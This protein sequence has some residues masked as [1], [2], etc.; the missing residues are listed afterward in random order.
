[1]SSS[2]HARGGQ[3]GVSASLV[4]KS[5]RGFV[6]AVA[7]TAEAVPAGGSVAALSGASA[8]AL[9]A[10]V[11]GVLRRK[12]TTGLA[13]APEQALELEERLLALV[14][15]DA[16]AFRAFLDD[17]R[18]QTAIARVSQAPLQVA[19]ACAEVVDLSRAVEERTSGPM[20]G[21]VRAARHLANAA[22]LAALDIAEQDVALQRDANARD[23]LTAQIEQLRRSR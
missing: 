7:S 4:E 13:G 15:E 21:D 3:A 18:S 8:A 23:S 1:M 12:E 2:S 10:L 5:V 11:C 9:L 22:L 6:D 20:L 19:R 14:D 17:K 16:N